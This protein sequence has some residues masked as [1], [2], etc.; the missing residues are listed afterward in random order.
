MN[1][2]DA[3]AMA[4]DWLSPWLGHWLTGPLIGT[5]ALVSG[6][7]VLHLVTQRLVL[8]LLWALIHR[9]GTWWDNVMMEKGVFQRLAWLIPLVLIHLGTPLVP[10][11]EGD[12]V[13]VVRRIT[14]AVMVLVVVLASQAVLA[15]INEIYR[16][17]HGA[18]GRTIK[19]YLQALGIVFWIVGG[20]LIVATLANQSPWYFL[21]GIGAM[22]AILLLIFRDTLLGLVAGVQLTANDLVRVGDWIEMPQFDADGDVVDITLH[23]VKVRNWDHTITVIPTHKFLEHSFRNWRHMFE[24]G[25][26]R[27]KR[28]LNIDM[29]TVRF[30]DAD[31]IVRFGRFD[32]LKDY[33]GEKTAELESW[34][35]ANGDGGAIAANNRRLT[36]L[37]TFRA[38]LAAY[39]RRHPQVHPQLTFLVRQL[40]PGPEG[41]PLE[42]YVFSN[43]TRWAMY[44]QLQADIFD[45]LLAML[46]EFGL[47]VF[48]KPTGA[49]L[50]Q[51][52]VPV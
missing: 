37:G 50:R 41:L 38:Y 7:V 3:I 33:I 28:A 13:D 17:Y 49:D 35:A 4:P 8:K 34:N 46:P 15:S 25:G 23:Q 11:L 22:T 36:N 40:Q 24:T 44:E 39:L 9:S 31:E 1:A 29:A 45:H 32:V 12:I 10:T 52:L 21:S 2:T 27:I 47:R 19:G 14:L 16:R 18:R 51:G 42:V 6:V 20:I 5:F 30:L 48:Q 26:R 43:D